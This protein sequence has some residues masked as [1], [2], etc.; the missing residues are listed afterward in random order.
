[1]PE[2]LGEFLCGFVY[3]AIAF[4]VMILLL[5]GLAAALNSDSVTRHPNRGWLWLGG[6]MV[7]IIAGILGLAG[8][9]GDYADRA[10]LTL[11]VPNAF[12]RYGSSMTLGMMLGVLAGVAG[13]SPL[14]FRLA[15]LLILGIR[16]LC[17]LP[18]I[19]R[20]AILPRRPTR[21]RNRRSR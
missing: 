1:M 8:L 9:V 3:G 15:G 21:Q 5:F 20:Q 6:I 14:V 13:G 19:L 11:A 7:A 17:R 10:G 4:P 2:F 12:S 16:A 18:A